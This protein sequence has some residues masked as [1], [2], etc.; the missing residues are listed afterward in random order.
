[1]P[2]AA[3][4][5]SSS[6]AG[7]QA[8]LPCRPP[9][10]RAWWTLCVG[11]AAR[12]LC[13]A[14]RFGPAVCQ[15]GDMEPCFCLALLGCGLAASPCVVAVVHPHTVGL[16]VRAGLCCF[17][18]P[19]QCLI[20]EVPFKLSGETG[21]LAYL[22][23]VLNDKGHAVVCVA[24]GAG[25][26]RDTRLLKPCQSVVATTSMESEGSGRTACGCAAECANGAA[27]Q[28]GGL[29][30]PFQAAWPLTRFAIVLHCSLQDI[31]GAEEDRRTDASGNPILKDVGPW[32]KSEIKKYFKD[33][34]VKYID[35][36]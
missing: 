8:S 3:S 21:M 9:W 14:P 13:K 36:S 26:V 5:W 18:A 4:G 22:E 2:T 30:C 32:L 34:D 24:E 11:H 17:H 31:L 7:S 12:L 29:G 16:R 1:M 35:P 25:Q 15:Y 23:K 10:P 33:A 19:P 20:P 27:V 28:P 6:W